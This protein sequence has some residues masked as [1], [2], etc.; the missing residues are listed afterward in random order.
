[1]SINKSKKIKKIFLSFRFYE[2]PP[3]FAYNVLNA[4]SP[5]GYHGKSI[6][7]MIMVDMHLTYSVTDELDLS[8]SIA[9]LTDED[10]PKA[11]HEQSYIA[12]SHSSMSRVTAAVF[13]YTFSK[14]I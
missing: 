2:V 5:F 8:L 7:D 4:S 13:R 10:P 12:F 3:S 1:M 9:N 6:E 14:N 11:P